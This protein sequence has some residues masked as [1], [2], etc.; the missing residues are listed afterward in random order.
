M[1]NCWKKDI[2]EFGFNYG[3]AKSQIY[4]ERFAYAA[5]MGRNRGEIKIFVLIRRLQII[6]I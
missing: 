6:A 3:L 1:K 2:I 5:V 4:S